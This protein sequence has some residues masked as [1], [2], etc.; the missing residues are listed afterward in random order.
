MMRRKCFAALLLLALLA[1]SHTV[2]AQTGIYIPSAKPIKNMKAAMIHP[3]TFCLLL[4]Y[5][6]S[7]SIYSINDLDI[8]DSVYNIAFDRD[9]P[10]LYPLKNAEGIP[11]SALM[12]GGGVQVGKID[13]RELAKK[14]LRMCE[15]RRPELVVPWKA[16]L[17]FS[18]AQMFPRL[19]DWIVLKET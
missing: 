8:L 9:N 7:D 4:Q 3:E 17:L 1:V 13:P 2:D 6:G 14:I 11:E 5:S 12:P 15:T 18:I 10:R 19:G 16:R